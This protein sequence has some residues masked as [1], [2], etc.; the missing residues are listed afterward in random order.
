A[1]TRAYRTHNAGAFALVEANLM[2]WDQI[3]ALAAVD[4]THAARVAVDRYLLDGRTGAAVTSAL[5]ALLL[6]PTD[7]R[8][9]MLKQAKREIARA[10]AAEGDRDGWSERTRGGVAG[11]DS[12]RVLDAYARMLAAPG[13]ERELERQRR[14][15]EEQDDTVQLHFDDDLI[16]AQIA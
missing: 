9:S 2:A 7:E 4:P 10:R 8:P 15:I 14:T 16:E 6:A 1:M 3:V 12:P 5:G 13:R 11:L